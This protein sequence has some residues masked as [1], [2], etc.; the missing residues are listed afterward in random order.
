MNK[1]R[2]NKRVLYCLLAIALAYFVLLLFPNMV[3]SDDLAMVRVFEPDEAAQLP[4]VLGMLAPAESPVQAARNFI[5]YGYYFY[6]FPFF[7][8]S[9]IA[10]FPLKLLGALNDTAQVMLVLRQIIGVL[11][12][13]VAL[14]LLVYLQDHFRTYRSIV[15]FIFLL[16]V[17]AVL[18]NGFWWHVDSLVFLMTTL[19]IYFLRKD[20]LRFGK[21]FYLAAVM[22]GMAT[23]TK[24]I[25]LF[26][27]L[28]IATLLVV[29]LVKKKA[30]FSQVLKA[31]LLFVAVMGAAY[32]ISNPFLASY[33][34][35]QEYIMTFNKQLG[36]LTQGYGVVY[37]KGLQ[38]A[39]PIIRRDYGLWIFILPAI[40][41]TLWGAFKSRDKLLHVII[42]TWF[43]PLGAYVIWFAHL[44]YQYWLPIALPL[45]TSLFMLLPEHWDLKKFFTTR[46]KG[47]VSGFIVLLLIAQ[48]GIYMLEDVPAYRQR[49]T[50]AQD[51]PQIAFYDQALD[52]LGP[53]ADQSLNVFFDYRL[54]V[55]EREGWTLETTYDLLSY[56][57]VEQADY[58]VLLLLNQRIA[59]YINPATSGI[60]SQQYLN[61]LT[62]YNDAKKDTLRGYEMVFRNETGSVFV[63]TERTVKITP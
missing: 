50:R 32:F 4:P 42:L 52:A 63:K 36:V 53:V 11:P 21:H 39:W 19:V 55:P 12:M 56:N 47:L 9:A 28:T 25:G 48:F 33:W 8:S 23:A 44:K 60:D 43:I 54:Y 16:A 49:L 1:I 41:A 3:A 35:R 62:F 30:T 45:F 10:I 24:L 26:F 14:L 51:N 17:P 29:A 34:A 38:Q 6:G 61:S 27:F 37:E 20:N 2:M 13:L 46:F 7:A 18:T 15:M 58:D 5:L 40:G 57:A 22:T 31:G 59:D